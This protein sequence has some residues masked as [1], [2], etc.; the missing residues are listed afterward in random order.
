MDYVYVLVEQ[1]HL[2]S[3]EREVYVDAYEKEE[4]AHYDMQKQAQ[5]HM[6]Q[7]D[8]RIID[9]GNLFIYMDDDMGNTYTF[10]IEERELRRSRTH[11]S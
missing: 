8:A 1:N 3:G 9:E 10:M 7:N 4:D 11:G 2:S 5:E 6:E